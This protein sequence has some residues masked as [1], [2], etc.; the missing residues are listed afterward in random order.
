[1]IKIY[2]IL[3]I[4]INGQVNVGLGGE[5]VGAPRPHLTS[6]PGL[7][8]DMKLEAVISFCFLS[9]FQTFEKFIFAT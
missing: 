1:M 9:P 6:P 8:T 3:K 7:C 2:M 5:L 4:R